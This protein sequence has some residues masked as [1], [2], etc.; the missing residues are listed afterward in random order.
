[1]FGNGTRAALA[2]S[3]RRITLQEWIVAYSHLKRAGVH[4]AAMWAQT[5]QQAFSERVEKHQQAALFPSPPQRHWAHTGRLEI[6]RLWQ[7]R[8]NAT[9]CDCDAIYA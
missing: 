4:G 9:F 5:K 7:V 1:M 3:L 6:S 8:N 2:R